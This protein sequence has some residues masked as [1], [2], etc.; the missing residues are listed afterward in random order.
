MSSV[1][2]VPLQPVKRGVL[3]HLW[4]GIVLA[5]IAAVALAMQAPVDPVA[6]FLAK[7]RREAG[8]VQTA[9]GLQYKML[10]PGKGKTPT[11]A[12]VTLV[13]Y[14]GT[15]ADGTRFDQSQRPMPFPLGE[16]ASIPG[17]EEGLKLIPKGGKY[18]LWIR[19]SLGYGSDEKK[20]QSGK[21]VIP[22]NSVLVF[23]VEMI[24]FMSKAQLQ[25]LQ[26]Q[27]QLQ[28]QMQQG[29]APGGAMPPGA[30]GPM[31]GQ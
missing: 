11:D 24:D 6:G 30:G 2:A 9:S 23:D 10:A 17:F 18:R 16:K 1:T 22:A 14:D 31:P 29:G 4:V 12:D 28:Q 3:V 26:M 13:M 7:N 15:L 25:Q 27:Q 5:V 19:P 8:V 21:V 20:D